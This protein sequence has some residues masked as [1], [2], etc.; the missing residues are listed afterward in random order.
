MKRRLTIG[1]FV[2]E[3]DGDF[4]TLFWTSIRKAAQK[5][6]VN[7]IA[8]EG[9][10]LFNTDNISVEHNIV[11]KLADASRLDG[12]IIATGTLINKV[13][14]DYFMEYIKAFEG[15]PKVSIYENIPG[16]PSILVDNKKGM[17]SLVDHL[18]NHHKYR[19][20]GFLK[21]PL[22][23][24]ESNE[25]YNAYL[26]VLEENGIEVD[27]KIIFNGNFQ[28]ETG[29]ETA[30]YLIKNNIKIDA[31]VCAND[32]MAV[33]AI[34]YFRSMNL[35]YKE[36]FVVCGFDNAHNSAIITPSLT[37]VMQPLDMISE[38]AIELLL[39]EINGTEVSEVIKLPTSTVIRESCGCEAVVNRSSTFSD[40]YIRAI[41]NFKVH[42]N[43]QTYSLDTLFDLLTTAL[44]KLYIK[45][46]FII[47]YQEGPVT[48]KSDIP[49]FSELMYAYYNNERSDYEDIPFK[50]R[51]LVPDVFIPYDRQFTYLVKPLFFNNEH[52]GFVCFEVDNDDVINFELLRGQISNTLKGALMLLEKE[53]MSEQLREQERMSTLGQLLI[54]IANNIKSYIMAI[55][56]STVALNSLIDEY[57]KSIT[58]KS[59]TIDD[60]HE[61]A[62]EMSSWIERID[63]NLRYMTSVLDQINDQYSKFT[64]RNMDGFSVNDLIDSIKNHIRK[65]EI[66]NMQKINIKVETDPQLRISGEIINL[67][68]VIDNI[69]VN[70]AY[71][72]IENNADTIDIRIEHMKGCILISLKDYGVGIPKAIKSSIFKKMVTTRGKNAT[73]I[74]LMLS[75]STIKGRFGGDLY[76][77]SETGLGTTF[78]IKLFL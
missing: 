56:G 45:S 38:K 71:A 58:D 62:E 72:N 2:N 48:V 4:Q 70:A 66:L 64:T 44:K 8:F 73:G 57:T 59:V 32:E 46:C 52:Y 10:I 39:E 61:I 76:F 25:R 20:I 17:K 1:F 33:G 34:K 13:S 7:L 18:V 28:S 50:T 68:Q 42:E 27:E 21:G 9:R 78:Y 51:M 40:Y 22:S 53:R 69:L 31:L 54:S 47:R 63:G 29:W 24:D 11:Y 41:S 55:A 3:I 43:L 75:Y 60:H 19:K 26:E 23:N 15:I 30:E 35:D 65:F 77:N 12:L 14:H 5:L 16:V 36:N 67:L 37:T 49:D 6:D 74:G